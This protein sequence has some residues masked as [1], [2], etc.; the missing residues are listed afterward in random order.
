[1]IPTPLASYRFINTVGDEKEKTLNISQ[2]RQKI[3]EIKSMTEELVKDVKEIRGD[4]QEI[5][6][7]VKQKQE[8][9]LKKWW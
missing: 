2:N 1:M 7:L 9:D 3:D 6:E 5:L 8:R 4:I